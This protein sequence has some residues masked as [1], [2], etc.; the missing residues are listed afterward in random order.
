MTPQEIL[1]ATP[2][3]VASEIGSLVKSQRIKM[4]ITQED[5][6]K[7]V[8]VPLSTYALF[9]QK[10]KLQLVNFIKVLSAIGKKSVLIDALTPD[11]IEDIGVEQYLKAKQD[12]K[13]K[14]YYRKE[15]TKT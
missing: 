5:F 13:S 11:T 7:K 8:G 14:V 3:E 9:E 1:F 10:G 12:K 15:T 4:A 2:D 6:A